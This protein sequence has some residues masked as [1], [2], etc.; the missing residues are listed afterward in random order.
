MRRAGLSNERA[1]MT[2]RIDDL[3]ERS[4][5]RP[6]FSSRALSKDFVIDEQRCAM[7]KPTR[8]IPQRVQRVRD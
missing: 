7:K 1:H 6:S 3:G 4:D 2:G 5:E 8:L